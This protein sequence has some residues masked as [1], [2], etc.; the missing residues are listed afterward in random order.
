VAAVLAA[1]V[2]LGLFAWSDFDR[3]SR[4]VQGI[5]FTTVVV[6]FGSILALVLSAPAKSRTTQLLSHPALTTFGKYSYALYLFHWP[7]QVA[8]GGMVFGPARFFTI[9]NSQL[10]GQIMFYAIATAAALTLAV[11]SWNLYEKQFLKLKALF[12]V[13]R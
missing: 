11:I 5:G 12:P 4:L 9:T 6:C 3:N 2:W 1:L 7:V 13:G 10:P 8:I